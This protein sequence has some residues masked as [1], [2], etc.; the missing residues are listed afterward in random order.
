MHIYNFK[1]I[2]K[3]YRYIE[4]D[5]ENDIKIKE[6]TICLNVLAGALIYRIERSWL[7]SVH[8]DDDQKFISFTTQ[9]H[10]RKI[11]VFFLP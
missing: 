2:I 7:D 6:F 9:E 1:S 4:R 11:Y 3:H 8:C 10:H 5:I